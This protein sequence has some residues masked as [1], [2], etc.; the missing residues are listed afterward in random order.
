M[1]GSMDGMTEYEKYLQFWEMILYGPGFSDN[2]NLPTEDK[3]DG[4]KVSEVDLDI[5]ANI[6]AH[7]T[8]KFDIAVAGVYDDTELLVVRRGQVFNMKIQFNRPYDKTKDD[9][10]FIFEFGKKPLPSKQTR[11]ELMLSDEDLPGKWG[12]VIKSKVGNWL[13]IA[14]FTPPDCAVAKWSLKIDVVK[15]KD[16]KVTVHRYQH[17]D[18]L[19]ILFNPWCKD[20]QVYMS[21]DLEEYVLED[22]GEIYC[23]SY[24]YIQARKWK[25]GQFNGN[26]LDCAM[27]LLDD[28]SKIKDH[29]RGDPVKVT[30]EISSLVNSFDNSGVLAG[31]WSSEADDYAD[32]KVP[33]HWT[34]SVEILKQYLKTKRPVKYGQ[35]WV[36]SGIVTTVCR[37]LG[38]PARSVTNFESAHGTDGSITIDTHFDRAG[39]EMEKYN[40]SVWNFHVWNDV[41]MARPNLPTGYDGWQAIDATPQEESGGVHCMGPMSVKAIK[42]GNMNLPHDG[43]FVFAEVNADKVTW[44]PNKNGNMSVVEINKHS[45]GKC[46]STKT[47]LGRTPVESYA[48]RYC[49]NR[50]DITNEYKFQE[51]SQEERQAVKRANLRSTKDNVYDEKKWDVV[52]SLDFK[53]TSIGET[54]NVCMK[55]KNNSS[56]DRTVFGSTTLTSIDYRG[57]LHKQID[58]NRIIEWMPTVLKAETEMSVTLDVPFEKYFEKLVDEC[59]LKTSCLYEVQETNQIFTTMEVMELAKTTLSIKAPE[60]GYIR[61]KF[62]VVATFKNPLPVTLTECEL[63]VEGPGLQEAATYPQKDVSAN[64]TFTGTFALTPEK[65]HEKEIIVKFNA[66]ELH[67]VEGKHDMEISK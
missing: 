32:G 39:D 52:F 44:R 40:D 23:G 61:K 34:G 13:N 63:T 43:P 41:W 21:K 12:A 50:E 47:P 64:A 46:I 16:N 5:K 3:D 62:T 42:E 54:V 6:A 49:P 8:D 57:K 48:S 35:C 67:S 4:L 1:D 2:T 25:F 20:D 11:Q 17:S 30:R 60:K 51:G 58:R 19:Y 22:T 31:N 26:V 66:K 28:V 55:I 59:F 24:N 38:I 53:Q 65:V 29:V 36:F 7:H 56:S 9:L 10:K 37:A 27:Y 14:V 33:W 15:R 45:V 18:P